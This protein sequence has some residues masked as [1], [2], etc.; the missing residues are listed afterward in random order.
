MKSGPGVTV[1]I[2][3]SNED[4]QA[5]GAV[6]AA[7]AGD[8]AANASAA[9][10]AAAAA[11]GAAAAATVGGEAAAAISASNAAAAAAGPRAAK[12]ELAAEASSAD[13]A[14]AAAAAS[15]D[16]RVCILKH[17]PSGGGSGAFG[18]RSSSLSGRVYLR[19]SNGTRHDWDLEGDLNSVPGD[20]SCGYHGVLRELSRWTDNDLRRLEMLLREQDSTH[21]PSVDNT[22]DW[23]RWFCVLREWMECGFQSQILDDTS[24]FRQRIAKRL[25]D[26]RHATVWLQYIQCGPTEAE[27]SEKEMATA[28]A[29]ATSLDLNYN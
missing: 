29:L 14:T 24:M 17:T 8:E 13:A 21:H 4:P 11:A 7:A 19:D 9:S 18:A 10:A 23:T 1:V 20:G 6:A 25:L 26:D 15:H 27:F 16:I 12:A 2:L 28:E 5:S 22:C 3:P